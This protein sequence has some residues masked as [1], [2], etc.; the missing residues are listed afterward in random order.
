MP[1]DIDGAATPLQRARLDAGWKQS[2][3]ITALTAAASRRG[4]R[5][6]APASLKAM[7]SRWENGGGQPDEVY[8]R[9]FCLVYGRDE[10]ELGFGEGPS[11]TGTALQVAPSLDPETVDYFRSVFAQHVRAD[12]LMGPHHLVDVV[13]AQASLLDEILPNARNEI[14][15]DLIVLACRYNEFTGWLYQDGGD[16]ASAMVYSDRAMDYAMAIGDS[17][18]IS[19]L[20][21]R[22]SNIASDL[23]S[24]VRALGL[25]EAALREASKVSPRIRALVLGQEARAHALRGDAD[26]CARSIDAALREVTRPEVGEEPVAS[27]CTPAYVSMQAATCWSDLK[28][29]SRA[30]PIF[31]KAIATLPVFMRRDQGLCLTRLATAYASEG[32][33]ARACHA[34]QKALKTVRTATS[35]RALHELRKLRELLAPWRRDEEVS[36]LTHSIKR[37]TSTT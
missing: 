27:Y 34:G 18:E 2:R 14:R 12:N 31:E 35:A 1:K 30:I 19:Y 9:L 32:D 33:K 28:S 17:C 37:L 16:P 10:D 24:P 7:L 23:E 36:E 3:V 15:D 11:S 29:P 13:R 6:A 21:M 20:L 8:Q 5:I 25:T 4:I 26:D 22:K